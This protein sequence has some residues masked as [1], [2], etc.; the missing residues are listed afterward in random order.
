MPHQFRAAC[1]L[2]CGYNGKGALKCQWYVCSVY[3]YVLGL[4]QVHVN[5]MCL[6]GP[7]TIFVIDRLQDQ[8][9]LL[10]VASVRYR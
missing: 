1:T 10:R 3:E 2:K 7:R 8:L 4:Y 9:V 5:N 6:G